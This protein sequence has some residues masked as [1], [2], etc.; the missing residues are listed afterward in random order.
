MA[1]SPAAKPV[2]AVRQITSAGYSGL[3][4]K[5]AS[6]FEPVHGSAPDIA[7]KHIANPIAMY[8]PAAMMLDFLGH[9]SGK[10]REAHDAILKA[11][12]ATL[13]EG[14]HTGDLGGKASTSEVGEAIAAKVA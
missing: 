9:S 10:E 4:R 13:I 6:L 3:S 7:G 5:F 14:P 8:L 2:L 12:E 1:V 11:I